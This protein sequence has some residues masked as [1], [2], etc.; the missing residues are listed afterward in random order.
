MMVH[1]PDLKL[2]EE[3][4]PF[5]NFTNNYQAEIQLL[6][7]LKELPETQAGV[8]ERQAILHGFHENWE[9]LEDFTYRRLDLSEVQTTFED[10]INKRSFEENGNWVAYFKLRVYE[11]ERHRLQAKFVQ[12]VLLLRGLQRKYFARLKKDT[13]PAGFGKEIKS[14][15]SFLN[16]LRLEAHEELIREDRFSITKIID[17]SR[18]LNQLSP[19]EIRDFWE[20][21]FTF[22]AWW[23]VAKGIRKHKFKFARF[24]NDDTLNI[25][26]FYHPGI[27][28]P[29]TNSLILDA[30]RNVLL[31]TG[32]NM[33]GKSTLLKAVGLCVYLAHTGLAVPAASCSVPFFS[34]IAIAINLSDSLRDGYSHF[35]AEIENLKGVVRATEGSGKCFAIFDEIFRG[36]NIDDALD[37]TKT[38]VNGLS[39]IKG[40]FFLISTHLLQLD[41]QLDSTGSQRVRKCFIECVLEN[42]SPRFS[43]KLREGWSQLRIGRLLFE[44]EGLTKM[45]GG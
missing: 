43:Y 20:F 17:F 6:S 9:V 11:A 26:N 14:A 28:V 32:P 23:S 34:S 19:Q 35:M 3:I 30:N 37:I 24:N 33:S 42:G 39:K 4:L 16:K 22:E 40:S 8:L 29:I 10:I 27:K 12:L 45:L 38:T 44:K 2:E 7:L 41:S 31:L 15:L 1:V 13:F 18:L 5:F 36:T 25:Q 21:F